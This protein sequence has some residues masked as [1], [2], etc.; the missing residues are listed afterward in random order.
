MQKK[1][2]FECYWAD[3]N[4]NED[5]NSMCCLRRSLALSDGKRT[6]VSD[7]YLGKIWGRYC[8]PR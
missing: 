7:F 1:L 4:R 6:E 2:V 5:R 8:L 3:L